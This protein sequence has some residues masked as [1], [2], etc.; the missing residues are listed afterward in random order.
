MLRSFS[1]TG[2]GGKKGSEMIRTIFLAGA[3]AL[4]FC[5]TSAEATTVFTDSTPGATTFTVTHN[6]TYQ[7]D[8]YGAQ[9][10]SDHGG[11]FGSGGAGAGVGGNF[12]LTAG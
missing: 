7:I 12:K 11:A 6:G 1:A 4:A 9:G 10:G 3:S 8:V 2:G 5:A